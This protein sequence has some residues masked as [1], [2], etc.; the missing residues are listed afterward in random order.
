MLDRVLPTWLRP[1]ATPHAALARA[2]DRLGRGGSVA[3]TADE[4]GWSARRLQQLMTRET[5]M[6]PKAYARVAR[7][8]RARRSLPGATSL[9]R[10]AADLGY[11]DQSHLSREFVAHAGLSPTA[12]L[13]AEGFRI[14]HDDL[15]LIPA[16]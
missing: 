1:G 2:L 11:A 14:V 3:D 9:A 13:A 12:W 5:G 7:F 10:L 4:V 8:D 6:A 15:L 16:R